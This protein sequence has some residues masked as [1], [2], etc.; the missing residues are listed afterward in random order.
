MLTEKRHVVQHAFKVPFSFAGVRHET[1]YDY[2]PSL[3]KVSTRLERD[4]AEAH[5]S[6]DRVICVCNIRRLNLTALII[7]SVTITSQRVSASP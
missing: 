6:T 5:L 3:Y 2:S 7:V 4:T 1:V